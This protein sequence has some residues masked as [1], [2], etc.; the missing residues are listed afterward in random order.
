MNITK[1]YITELKDN[2]IFVFG[3]NESGRHGKGA[4]K[5]AM[6]WGAIYGKPFGLQGK[7]FGIPTVNASITNKLKI[8]KIKIYVDKFIAI[9][10]T[11]P[12][13]KFLVTEIG[14]GLAGHNIKDIAP[15]FEEC[16]G[17]NNIYLPKRFIRIIKRKQEYERN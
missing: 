17:L 13:L 8:K 1:D 16:L 10:K 2:E 7:T 14:C 15:L 9:T 6:K 3:S 5:T 4:A 11:K 12:K